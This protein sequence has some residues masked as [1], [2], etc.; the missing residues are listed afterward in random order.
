LGTRLVGCVSFYD[1]PP[2]WMAAA[3]TS[4][5]RLCDH[6]VCLDGA[7]EWF[8]AGLPSSG[9][10]AAAEILGAAIGTGVGITYEA[11]SECWPTEVAKRN[12]LLELACDDG[13]LLVLDGDEIIRNAPAGLRQ[14]LAV[15]DL[16]VATYT[17]VDHDGHG[18]ETRGIYRAGGL[19]Y[20]GAHHRLL[21]GDVHLLDP[22]TP[23]ESTGLRV[24]HRVRTG[25]RHVAA[26]EYAE[27]RELLGLE[28]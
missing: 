4:L 5:S 20:E 16:D 2:G 14:Q 24:Q 25:P 13:W 15:T 12:R 6:V 9:P 7:Y 23:A 28:R 27:R 3:V 21:R 11:P 17:L 22:L 1:E 19:R 10:D 8:P 18:S 26:R